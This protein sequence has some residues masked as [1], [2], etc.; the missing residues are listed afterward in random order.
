MKDINLLPED[1]NG[2]VEEKQKAKMPATTK[3][4]I[5]TALIFLTVVM[6]Y[7]LPVVYLKVMRYRVDTTH[8]KLSSKTFEN[9]R[10]VKAENIKFQQRIDSK[11]IIIDDIDVKNVYMGDLLTV[12]EKATPKGCN[13]K[14]VIYNKNLLKINGQAEKGIIAAEFLYNMEKLDN[15]IARSFNDGMDLKSI[16][17]ANDFELTFSIKGKG[18][19]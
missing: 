6:T 10:N 14:S 17:G 9:V 3:S 4:I 13:V 15:I 5:I 2:D 16:Q 12:I 18:E 19:K 1:V 7:I 11:E 8:E